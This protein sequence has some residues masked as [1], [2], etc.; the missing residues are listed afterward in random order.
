MGC[1]VFLTQKSIVDKQMLSD[2]KMKQ[3]LCYKEIKEQTKD[4]ILI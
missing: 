4:M 3:K 2:E 1:F